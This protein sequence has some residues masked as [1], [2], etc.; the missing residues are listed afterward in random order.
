MAM[1]RCERCGGQDD[2]GWTDY[3]IRLAMELPL[4]CATCDPRQRC[5]FHLAAVHAAECDAAECD[6][7]EDAHRRMPQ[8]HRQ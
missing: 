1:Y 5:H 6:A 4:L 2:T 7:A 3:Y 8:R